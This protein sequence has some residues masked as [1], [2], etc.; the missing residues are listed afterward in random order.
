MLF[1]RFLL[2]RFKDAK[3]VI[4]GRQEFLNGQTSVPTTITFDCSHTNESTPNDAVIQILNM[5]S[6]VQ[7]ELFQEGKR[8]EIEAGY[9][10]QNGTRDTGIIFKG[11]IRSVRTYVDNGVDVVSE[12][13]FGD[14]DDAANVRRL[15]KVMPAGTTHGE[16]VAA[17]VAAM[18]ADGV[19]AGDLRVP[20]YVEARPVTIDR[21]AWREI[22]DICHQHD[23][24]WSIQDGVLNVYPADKPLRDKAL[25]LTPH[26]GV[27]D[28]PEFTHDGVELKTMLLHFLRPGDTFKLSNPYV[29][30]RAPEKYRV[31]EINFA[32]SNQ[33]SDFGATIKAKVMD[34]SGKVKRSRD[35]RTKRR[36]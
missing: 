15:R 35:R 9:W 13:K 34:T 3:K 2:V 30:T 33:G 5:S 12:L 22:E 26:S 25:I 4:G 11:Q 6:A 32:G 21:P 1:N 18:E 14:S 36:A 8:V 27:L 20:Q 29:T 24:I 28:A 7:R 19:T 16:I 23:L 17:A 31:E 10:P